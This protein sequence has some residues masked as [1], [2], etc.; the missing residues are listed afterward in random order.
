MF[1]YGSRSVFMVFMIPG[2]FSVFFAPGRFF[3]VPDC[4]FFWFQADFHGFSR[5]KAGF[6]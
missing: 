3:M 1:F 6:S 5:F 4:F 2:W